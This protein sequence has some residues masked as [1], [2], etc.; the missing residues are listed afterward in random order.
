MHLVHG[1]L[2]DKVLQRNFLVS[3]DFLQKE[4]TVSYMTTGIFLNC[5]LSQFM[6][7]PP[8]IVLEM[9]QGTH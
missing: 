2:Q 8:A 9:D 3:P 6:T 5:S 1:T 4:G 7:R